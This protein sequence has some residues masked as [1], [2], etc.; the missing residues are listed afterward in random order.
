MSDE[1]ADRADGDAAAGS[2]PGSVAEDGC[3]FPTGP[4][5]ATCRRP[6]ERSGAPGRPARYCDR[7]DHDRAK[8]FAARRALDAA[9][10]GPA[11]PEQELIAPERPVTDGR[12]SFGALLARF[13]ETATLA[14]RSAAEQQAQLAAILER[15]TAVVR[16]V[17]DPD[18]A[19][20][21]VEQIQRETQVRIAEAQ[22]AQAGAER[23]AREH[24][25]AA[26]RETELRAQADTAA[27]DALAQLDALRAETT[28]TL[29]RVADE[30]EAALAD[31]RDRADQA[32]AAESAARE[33]M[34]RLRQETADQVAAARVDAE[35]LI[36]ERQAEMRR[37]IEAAQ[38]RA[39]DRI[40]AAQRAAEQAID[41][42]RT[43][44]LAAEQHAADAGAAQTRAEAERASAER[45]ATEDRATLEG[46]RAELEQQRAEHHAELV[47]ARREAAEERA[48]L[49][50]DASEQ[51]RAVLA[52][53]DAPGRTSGPADTPADPAPSDASPTPPAAR[54]RGRGTTASAPDV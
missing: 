45:R 24:R 44:I 46:V 18:A 34:T 41:N 27:E 28:E 16:T 7:P 50:R 13:E 11:G 47:A 53:F 2:R 23:L 38:A 42:V 48:A 12:A 25:R 26:E 32:V 39:D 49:R 52:R 36:A 29:S 19:G 17:A 22:T 37:E 51:L 20:Y 54:R 40:A 14:Q 21:E 9:G 33:E 30:H 1:Q 3:Q 6:I 8:A 43:Q 5:G 35:Q 15:A 4:S 31:Q 10:A